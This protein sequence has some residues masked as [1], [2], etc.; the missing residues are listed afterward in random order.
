MTENGKDIIIDITDYTG[1][2]KVMKIRKHYR[3]K[4]WIWALTVALVIGSLGGAGGAGRVNGIPTAKAAVTMLQSSDGQWKYRKLTEDKLVLTKYLGEKVENTVNIPQTVDGMTVMAL[5]TYGEDDFWQSSAGLQS[6]VIPDSVTRIGEAVFQNCRDLQRV[7][8]GNAVKRLG[9]SAFSGCISL[10]SIDLKNA[11]YIG[12]NAFAMCSSLTEIDMNGSVKSVGAYAFVNCNNLVKVT[13]SANVV[14]YGEGVFFG[15]GIKNMKLCASITKLPDM[16]FQDCASLESVELVSSDLQ[17]VGEFAFM[18]CTSL[19][20]VTGLD[21]VTKKIG[22]YAFCGCTGLGTL[23]DAQDGLVGTLISEKIGEFAFYETAITELTLQSAGVMTIDPYAFQKSALTKV[24]FLSPVNIGDEAFADCT[25]LVTLEA[26]EEC[27]Q[28]SGSHSF[29]NTPWVT[30]K[31]ENGLAILD[32]AIVDTQDDY[33]FGNLTIPESVNRITDCAFQDN[34]TLTSVVMPDGVTQIG[35]EAFEGCDLLVQVEFADTDTEIGKRA[36]DGTKWLADL[37]DK[38]DSGLL[39]INDT[40]LVDCSTDMAGEVVIPQ[41]VRR[42][43][44]NAFAHCRNITS[45][46]F[47]EGSLLHN[48]DEQA[49]Y[50]CT[51]L[52]SIAFPDREICVEIPDE[53]SENKSVFY[54]CSALQQLTI[55]EEM[56]PSRSLTADMLGNLFEKCDSLKTLTIHSNAFMPEGKGK[57]STVCGVENIILGEKI[58]GVPDYAFSEC[59]SLKTLQY[60]ENL[61][62]IGDYAF[63]S[64]CEWVTNSSESQGCISVSD[65]LAAVNEDK[66]PEQIREE[67]IWNLYLYGVTRISSG[68][69]GSEEA[70]CIIRISVDVIYIGPGA[71]KPGTLIVAEPGSYAAKWA[72]ENGYDWVTP[73]DMGSSYFPFYWGPD[74]M[75]TPSPEPTASAAVPTS[76]PQTSTPVQETALPQGTTVAGIKTVAVSGVKVSDCKVMGKK[77]YISA[78]RI[79]WKKAEEGEYLIYRSTQKRTGYVL[80]KSTSATNYVDRQVKKGNVYFYKVKAGNDSLEQPNPLSAPVRA[81]VARKLMK[82]EMAL[83]EKGTNYVI[84]LKKAEGTRNEFQLKLKGFHGGKWFSR[85]RYQ[86]NIRKK[87]IMK[88]NSGGTAQFRMRIRTSMKVKGKWQKSSWS[89]TVSYSSGK[90]NA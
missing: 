23:A 86:G 34:T 84:S 60:S 27:Y 63:D 71:F 24:H 38:W 49:F 35:D 25:N 4:F 77:A 22:K 12:A 10:D 42:I 52:E 57:K 41:K 26:L 19:T 21:R 28:K 16:M 14:H 53:D 47:A 40:V 11:E 50:N 81:V 83:T 18:D 69:F 20:T 48:V 2:E 65:T 29:R 37:T 79:T 61:T 51:S 13:D 89:K 33:S 87:I 32:H 75:Q 59:S 70:E 58:T 39:I 90:K 88:R 1:M 74:R 72:E 76:V 67:N 46:S 78:L 66:L 6:V 17:E 45:I 43:E 54:G 36:F 44:E 73:K 8:L 55:P 15:T 64:N 85:K 31:Y 68:A 30:Q 9:T 7:T 5:D 56:E 3:N 82:P 62:Q 80:I